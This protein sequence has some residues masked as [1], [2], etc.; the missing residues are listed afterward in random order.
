[1]YT[2]YHLDSAQDITI[3]IIDSIKAAFQSK[4]IK[5]IITEDSLDDLD[6]NLASILEERLN[7][8]DSEYI[9]AEASITALNKKYGI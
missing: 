9:T 5:I 4:P 7:M 6:E 8:A 2:T 1:M 3:D